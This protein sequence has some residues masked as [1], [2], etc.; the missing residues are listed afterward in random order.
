[1]CN[2]IHYAG[3]GVKPK[4]G[5]RMFRVVEQF[6]IQ[7]QIRIDDEIAAAVH[8]GKERGGGRLSL[9][10]LRYGLCTVLQATE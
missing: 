9:A 2:I 1:M 4:S 7:V 10:W 3:I 8:G 6:A 5:P